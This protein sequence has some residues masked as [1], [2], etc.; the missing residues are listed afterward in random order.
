ME[1]FC[2]I[3]ERSGEHGLPGGSIKILGSGKGL[4]HPKGH[5][6]NSMADDNSSGKK[7][8]QEGSY[9]KHSSE[10]GRIY[11]TG[12]PEKKR[13]PSPKE[14]LG[15]SLTNHTD[16]LCRWESRALDGKRGRGRERRVSAELPLHIRER[17]SALLKRIQLQ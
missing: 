4:Q 17:H 14:L 6:K 16:G 5:C 3:R 13:I 11:P 2:R 12:W 9:T 8:R 1:G 15:R 10:M 7:K